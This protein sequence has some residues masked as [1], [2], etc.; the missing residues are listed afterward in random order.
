VR[1]LTP[2]QAHRL[3]ALLERLVEALGHIETFLEDQASR[4]ALD[5]FPGFPPVPRGTKLFHWT[6]LNKG[7]LRDMVRSLRHYIEGR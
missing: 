4:D 2:H 1:K 6:L 7:H 5:D 3:R